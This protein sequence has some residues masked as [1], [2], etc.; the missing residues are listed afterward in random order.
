M[1]QDKAQGS[2]RCANCDIEIEWGPT[3]L[4]GTTFCC[5]GCARGGPCSC[6]YSDLPTTPI[7]FNAVP[8]GRGYD[9]TERF[10]RR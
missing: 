6:D 3:I 8:E 9:S 1:G 10:K 5:E 2:L 7:V 4:R